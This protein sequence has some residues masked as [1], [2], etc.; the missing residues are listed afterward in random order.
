M[1]ET[2]RLSCRPGRLQRALDRHS[3]SLGNF[4]PFGESVPVTHLRFLLL[5]EEKVRRLVTGGRT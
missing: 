1:A 4:L 3:H 2:N 5:V